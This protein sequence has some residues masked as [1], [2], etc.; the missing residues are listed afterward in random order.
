MTTVLTANPDGLAP[1]SGI[2]QATKSGQ[3]I[4]LTKG[5]RVP[6]PPILDENWVRVVD[7]NKLRKSP[8]K[9]VA[10]GAGR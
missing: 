9:L 4:K 6:T 8:L 10:K 5:Q 3:R 2:Y 7:P 1:E